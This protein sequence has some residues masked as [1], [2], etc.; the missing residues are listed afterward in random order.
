M[1][2]QNPSDYATDTIGAVLIVASVTLLLLYPDLP[3]L[4]VSSV[5]FALTGLML[6]SG[7]NMRD[8]QVL[9]W[10]RVGLA[11]WLAMSPWVVGVTAIVGVTWTSTI[12]ATLVFV[13]AALQVSQPSAFCRVPLPR[14]NRDARSP[15]K[16]KI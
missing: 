2:N 7:T 3:D 1:R 9:E 5:N 16:R 12:C 14:P 15:E 11:A 13:P 8:R 4:A 6:L 10:E